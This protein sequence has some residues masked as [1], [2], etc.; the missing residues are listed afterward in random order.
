MTN[1]QIEHIALA[2]GFK[3]KQQPDGSMA[4][5]PYVFE[6]ARALL[7]EAKLPPRPDSSEPTNT[8]TLSRWG[9]KW[10]GPESPISVPMSDG[11]WTPWHLAEKEID[12]LK[13]SI[14]ALEDKNLDMCAEKI[15]AGRYRWLRE[16]LH[17]LQSMRPNHAPE[18]D[19]LDKAIDA[20]LK[21][22]KNELATN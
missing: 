17:R 15:D 3:L 12:D 7:F 9:I 10:Q 2:N 11:Y 20:E 22:E 18:P 4:L 6:F 16:N 13:W 19:A 21:E 8:P 14:A 5:N 1:E